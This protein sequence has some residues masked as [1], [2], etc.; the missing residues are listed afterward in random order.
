MALLGDIVVVNSERLVAV[1]VRL[2]KLR[3]R[4]RDSCF[5]KLLPRRAL[6]P[7]RI[8]GRLAGPGAPDTPELAGLDGLPLMWALGRSPSETPSDAPRR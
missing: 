7:P 6:E 3:R 2:A 1:D 4:C 5:E 8:A